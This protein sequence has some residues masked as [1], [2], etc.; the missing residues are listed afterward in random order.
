MSAIREA[1]VDDVLTICNLLRDH[2]FRTEGVFESG[3]KYWV[4]EAGARLV[5]AIGLELGYT[6]VLL[7]SAIVDPHLRGKGLGRQLTECA[8]DW[9]RRG[10]YVNAYCFSTDA[11]S[12]WVT[13]GFRPCSVEEVVNALP[14]APQVQLLHRR[15]LK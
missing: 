6:S 8:L 3:T 2:D 10:R 13:R 5:G 15:A 9:A 14:A 12:Y 7:R 4:A 11:G 1:T